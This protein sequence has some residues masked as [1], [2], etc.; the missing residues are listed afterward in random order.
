MGEIAAR[1]L[2][3]VLENE[4]VARRHVLLDTALIVRG[5]TAAPARAARS[6]A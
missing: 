5:S 1:M 3:A 4:P 2:V 6:V